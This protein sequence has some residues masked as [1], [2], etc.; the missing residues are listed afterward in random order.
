MTEWGRVR[1][2]TAT[3]KTPRGDSRGM[4][5][6][7]EDSSRRQMGTGG[8]ESQVTSRKSKV[9]S[10]GTGDISHKSKVTSRKSQV[11]S[12]KSKVKSQKSK[13]GA[14]MGMGRGMVV[15]S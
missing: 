14:G 1:S 10:T 13:A 5:R 9:K 12:H 11:E 15:R 3:S 8:E 7:V 2:W 4:D 6:H